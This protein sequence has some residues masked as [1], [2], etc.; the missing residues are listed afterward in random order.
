MSIRGKLCVVSLVEMPGQSFQHFKSS[1]LLSAGEVVWIAHG[2]HNNEWLNSK[3]KL[4]YKNIFLKGHEIKCVFV[5]LLVM[6]TVQ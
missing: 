4:I 5:S 2:S 3:P 6:V 1:G